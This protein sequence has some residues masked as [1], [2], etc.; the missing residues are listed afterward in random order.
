MK[1]HEWFCSVCIRSTYILEI[2]STE[3][4]PS[5][6]EAESEALLEAVKEVMLLFNY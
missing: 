6:S 1:K 2:K 3:N 4:D 5:N